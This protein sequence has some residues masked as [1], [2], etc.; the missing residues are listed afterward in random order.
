[1]A[2]VLRPRFRKAEI[3]FLKMSPDLEYCRQKL[4]E[5]RS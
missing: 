5:R 3:G 1:M 2:I 4:L